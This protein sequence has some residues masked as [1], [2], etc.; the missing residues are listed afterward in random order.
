M[1]MFR[2]YKIPKL[3][4]FQMSPKHLCFCAESAN[5]NYLN[6]NRLEVVIRGNF[7]WVKNAHI[8]LI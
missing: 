6:F 8:C 4:F 7:K 2:F 1:K 3:F 5:F